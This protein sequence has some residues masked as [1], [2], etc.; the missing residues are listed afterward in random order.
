MAG[1]NE[2]KKF[3]AFYIFAFLFLAAFAVVSVHIVKYL[4]ENPAPETASLESNK[5]SHNIKLLISDINSHLS[6]QIEKIEIFAAESGGC[7]VIAYSDETECFIEL[8]DMKTGDTAGKRS[9]ELNDES[10]LNL[11]E[12]QFGGIKLTTN[13]RMITIEPIAANRLETAKIKE[14]KLAF[15]PQGDMDIYADEMVYCAE[16]GLLIS[17]TN[18]ENARLIAS[19]ERFAYSKPWL[20]ADEGFVIV[21]AVNEL[22]EQS[23]LIINTETGKTEKKFKL[24]SEYFLQKNAMAKGGKY[25]AKIKE[26]E[27]SVSLG[28]YDVMQ[29]KEYE[30]FAGITLK[31]NSEMLPPKGRLL[32]NIPT[33]VVMLVYCGE[34]R[35]YHVPF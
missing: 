22:K 26:T 32:N 31:E 2:K 20:M 5:S 17:G 15:L 29:E 18:G 8:T 1:S 34:I 3:A 9:F 30:N 7:L 13:K 19:S 28:L 11:K 33:G 24:P 10:L 27:D 6:D 35:I 14:E 4:I 21:E 16:E 12:T 23:V 25:V